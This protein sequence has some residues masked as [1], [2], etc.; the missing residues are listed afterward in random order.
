MRDIAILW[1]LTIAFIQNLDAQHYSLATGIRIGDN[2]GITVQGKLFR[3]TSAEVILH[4]GIG[5]NSNSVSFLI[6]RHQKILTDRISLFAGGGIIQQWKNTDTDVT[7][8]LNTGGIQTILG[9]ELTIGRYNISWDFAPSL[10]LWGSKSGA[11]AGGTAVSVRYV[12]IAPPSKKFKLK[13]H[14]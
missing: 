4:P 12:L 3:K 10:F 7:G 1:V 11:L 5:N 2:Y 14:K 8:N 6:K 9:A 13:L